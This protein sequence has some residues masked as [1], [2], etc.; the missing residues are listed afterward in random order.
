[1]RAEHLKSTTDKEMNMKMTGVLARAI[2]AKGGRFRRKGDPGHEQSLSAHAS[3]TRAP[4]WQG[5]QHHRESQHEHR[6]R[7]VASTVVDG[8][9]PC[10][11]RVDRSTACSHRPRL[12]RRDGSSIET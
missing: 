1:M 8:H 7:S 3:S 10:R 2:V 9:V 12:S 5:K 11:A 6:Q 4:H